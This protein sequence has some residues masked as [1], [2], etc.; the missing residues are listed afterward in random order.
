[1]TLE[2]PT[3][4]YTRA[5]IVTRKM[6]SIVANDGVPNPEWSRK[7]TV[8]GAD[9][10]IAVPPTQPVT[11]IVKDA[12]TGEPMP[13]V[14]IESYRMTQRGMSAGR[15]IRVK[16]DEDGRYTLTGLPKGAGSQIIAVPNDDQ[17]YLMRVFDVPNPTGMKPIDLDLELNKGVWITGN[18][19]NKST[20]K[21]L[22]IKDEAYVYY[23]P[24]LSN[25]FAQ[26]TPEY[27]RENFDGYQL[28]YKV[29]ADGSYRLVGLPG[30]AIV[31]AM[32]GYEPYPQGQGFDNIEGANKRGWFPTFR[33]GTGPGSKW[34]TILREVDIAETVD[35]FELDFQL[36]AGKKIAIEM[37]DPDGEALKGVQVNGRGQGKW[38]PTISTSGFDAVAF[39]SGEKRTMLFHHPE[40]KL[41]KVERVTAGDDADQKLSVQLQPLVTIRGRLVDKDDQP[42]SGARIRIEPLPNEDFSPNLKKNVSTDADGRFEHSE[43]LPGT[44]YAVLA[45]STKMGFTVVAKK[46]TVEPGETIDLQTIN[47]SIKKRPKPIRK[48]AGEQA[49]SK[50][51]NT[52]S[53]TVL[54]ANRKPVAGAEIYS[55]TY[56]T[57]DHD[58]PPPKLVATSDKNGKYSF[59]QPILNLPKD[60]PARWD[61]KS[62]LVIK[63]PGHGFVTEHYQSL[64]RQLEERNSAEG[65]LA[66][67]FMGIS[68]A[69]IGLP[70]AGNPIKGR[71]VDI[72]GQPVA[73]AKIRIQWFTG[74]GSGGFSGRPPG[75]QTGKFVDNSAEQWEGTIDS[76]VQ[77]IEPQRAIDAFPTAT[78]DAD[79]RFEL[80]DIG[81]NRLFTLVIQGEGIETKKVYAYNQPGKKVNAKSDYNG[82]G[83]D[84]YNVYPQEFTYIAGPSNP[85]TGKVVDYD[86]DEPIPNALVI[87]T[88]LHGSNRHLGDAQGLFTVKTDD[89]G[90]FRMDGLPV[91]ARNQLVCFCKNSEAPYPLLGFPANT[92][93]GPIEEEFRMKQGVWAEGGVFDSKTKKPWTGHINYYY[94]RNPELETKHRGVRLAHLQFAYWT[95]ND[96]R[97]RVPV[98]PTRG[99]LCYFHNPK[100]H[101]EARERPINKYPRGMLA[102]E[103]EGYDK[104][105]PMLETFPSVV[106]PDNYWLTKE[107]N[108]DGS[109]DSITADMPLVASRSLVVKTTWP[110]GTDIKNYRIFNSNGNQFWNRTDSAE[111]E[112]KALKQG[113]RRD[114]FAF[115][116]GQNLIGKAT[117]DASMPDGTVVE[118]KDIQKAGFIVGQLV[119]EDGEPITNAIIDAS[120]TPWAFHP[121]KMSNPSRIPT[122]ENGNFRLTGI[123]PG[124]SYGA[125]VSA[126]RKYMNGMMNMN[127]GDAFSGVVV[128]PGETKDLGQLRPGAKERGLLQ[129]NIAVESK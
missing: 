49:K 128:K 26:T 122:D 39:E 7:Y 92:S 61:Y 17:P 89:E 64:I 36:D 117:V 66:K 73:N 116:R 20:G 35:S 82:V 4:A 13:D 59:R 32:V 95:N 14:A 126:P 88:S 23:F 46:L 22:E 101:E 106:F 21:N 96:G 19:T 97:F 10:V 5:T 38:W 8:H 63:A 83:T 18:L 70:P 72:D 108:P 45:E 87:A 125:S 79:G 48:A 119:D 115:H 112:V 109:V 120:E 121:G 16:T 90:K 47:A 31:G 2:G 78:T 1:M 105:R 51:D 50:N 99:L 42:V 37:T 104:G 118:I 34:P 123:V 94:M 74:Y 86:T 57:R 29:A 33:V 76:L 91:G 65:W 111:V 53:G 69:V 110:D 28:R 129:D 113:E 81:A 3:I 84:K 67:T 75:K 56:R 44:D 93:S 85:V 60:A 68:G 58:S 9:C 55:I 71:V 107:I 12:K 103:I 41:G 100:S 27:D 11:G 98:W 30:K 52:I 124:K 43:V 114:I 40:R 102:S 62:S 24:Y 127:I 77:T 54:G 25:P 6:K 80:K 15:E